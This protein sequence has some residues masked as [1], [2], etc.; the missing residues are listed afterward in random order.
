MPPGTVRA[1][2]A[3]MVLF[4]ICLMNIRGIQIENDFYLILTT[5]IGFYFGSRQ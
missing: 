4:T 2:M 5:I 3:L 1:F